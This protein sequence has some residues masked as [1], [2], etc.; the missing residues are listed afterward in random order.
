MPSRPASAYTAPVRRSAW[1]GILLSVAS[2]AGVAY[3]RPTTVVPTV[4]HSSRSVGLP[5]EGRLAGGVALRE[6]AALRFTPEYARGGNFFGTWELV[7]M[8]HRAAFGV[9][10][11][12]PGAKL[13][14]GEISKVG[15]GPL[16]G[17]NSHQNGR[18]VDLA[19]YMLDGRGRPFEPWAF[20]EFDE[21]G[22]GL[23]PNDGLRFDDARNWELVAKLVSDPDARVQFVFVGQGLRRRLLAEAARRNA[24]PSL[25]AR[26]QRVL[27]QPAQGHPH[28]NHFHV[29]IYCGNGS[30]RCEDRAPFH[31]WYHGPRR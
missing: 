25:I 23:A 16:P 1:L 28:R 3:A 12:F 20:A 19:F 8:L 5:F 29:R 6:T 17:H 26:A 4:R 9:A 11:R 18:D 14:V 2:V 27:V 7:Q 31:P 24:S 22:R 15:G 13:S 10:R 30:P 21:L